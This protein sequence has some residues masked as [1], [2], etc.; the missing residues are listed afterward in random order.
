MKD[1]LNITIKKEKET[2]YSYRSFLDRKKDAI[3]LP[4]V[5]RNMGMLTGNNVIE[6]NEQIIGKLI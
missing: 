4:L 3:L 6:K 2:N 5:S 1:K